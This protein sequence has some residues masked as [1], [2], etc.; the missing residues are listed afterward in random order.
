MH[1][2]QNNVLD[3]IIGKKISTT[4][5]WDHIQIQTIRENLA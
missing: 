4:S 5:I 3:D 1:L 2:K